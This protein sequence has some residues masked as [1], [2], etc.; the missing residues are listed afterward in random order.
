MKVESAEKIANRI[1]QPCGECVNC[2]K[3]DCGECVYCRDMVKFGGGGKRKRRCEKRRCVEIEGGGEEGGGMK[4]AGCGRG[5]RENLEKFFT[6]TEMKR[7]FPRCKECVKE[8][9]EKKPKI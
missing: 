1:T 2:E 9:R 7:K 4:C 5:W 6:N 3:E 8:R